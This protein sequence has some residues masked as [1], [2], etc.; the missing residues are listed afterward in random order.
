MPTKILKTISLVFIAFLLIFNLFFTYTVG[1]SVDR[2]KDK[3]TDIERLA[4]QLQS[5]K[6]DFIPEE[7]GE[8]PDQS[9]SQILVSTLED[10]EL[11]Q[12]SQNSYQEMLA[13]FSESPDTSLP[14]D[15]SLQKTGLNSFQINHKEN[16]LPIL[17]AS[18]DNLAQ[19]ITLETTQVYEQYNLYQFSSFQEEFQSQINPSNLQKIQSQ[20]SNFEEFQAAIQNLASNQTF[21]DILQ[22]KSLNPINPY[23]SSQTAYYN[24]LKDGELMAQIKS[25]LANKSFKVYDSNQ[26]L[27]FTTIQEPE[28]IQKFTT[29]LE[30]TQ[31]QTLIQKNIQAKINYI[32]TQ[33]NQPEVLTSLKEKDLSISEPTDTTQLYEISILNSSQD[34][35]LTIKID[36]T[37]SQAFL[38]YKGEEKQLDFKDLHFNTPEEE[39]TTENHLILGKHGSLTDTIMIANFNNQT[40]QVKLISLPRDL[41]LDNKKINSV[42]AY[43]GLETLVQEIEDLSGLKIDKYALVDMYTFID[44]VD[45]LGGINVE[46]DKPLIDPSYVTFDNDQWGTLKLEAGTHQVNGR[47]ALR[48]ARSRHSTSDFDRAHRQ[49]LIL[50]GLQDRITSLGAK[51]AQTVTEVALLGIDST[52]TNITFKEALKYYSKYKDYQLADSVVL[53]TA[54]ILESTYTGALN[55]N[56]NSTTEAQNKGAYILL[57]KNNDWSLLRTFIYSFLSN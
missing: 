49:H 35:A 36:K 50:K 23:Y 13:F 56:P 37:T 30:N 27:V 4:T 14:Q 18:Y 33:L 26:T 53:S 29:F 47:Q 6:N 15:F 54:N 9:L 51:D 11:E 21:Q 22:T 8:Y 41:Y 55:N 25:S 28:L 42:Y 48:I 24:L 32:Q 17:Q 43:R 20:I 44:I 52:E 40:Q 31:F 10:Y 39:K 38:I 12:E 7:G 3:N 57:P 1:Y 19:I 46:L 5:L 34:P 45:T 2:L 16:S